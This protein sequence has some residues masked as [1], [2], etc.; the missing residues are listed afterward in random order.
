[1][2]DT[3]Q[4]PPPRQAEF[5]PRFLRWHD[6]ALLALVSFLGA[7]LLRLLRLTLRLEV[8]DEEHVA[9]FWN[10]GENV[11]V[12]FWHDRFLMLP[13]AYRGPAGVRVLISSSNDGE[14]IARTIHRFG[15]GTVR[16][17]SSRGGG[18]AF[19]QLRSALREG[20]DVGITPDGPKGPRHRCKVG[21]IELARAT[22]RPVVPVLMSS[23]RGK[24]VRSWDRFLIPVP[25]DRVVLRWGPP[26]WA[27]PAATF[28][29][30]QARIDQ[31][32]QALLRRVDD[33]TGNLDP[34]FHEGP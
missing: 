30:D 33:E 31:A 27:D 14:L 8:R 18:I 17:S 20:Y 1:M 9:Q 15:L 3:V 16:G 6:R 24:R 12:A 28:E 13:F 32:M 4:L 22:G 7:A 29:S 19:D 11:I 10:R 5:P 34:D 21:V 23:V 26:I 2:T 25:F